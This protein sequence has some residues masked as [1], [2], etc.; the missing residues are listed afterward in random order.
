MKAYDDPKTIL[1]GPVRASYANV[2]KPRKKEG[3]NGQPDRFMFDIT[4]LIPKKAHPHLAA[5]QAEY[6]GIAEAVRQAALHKFGD[7]VK[8]Y[9]NPLKDGDTELR[10]DGTPV[11]PGYWFVAAN[12]GEDY[13]PLVLGPGRERVD[14]SSGYQSGDW[15]KAKIN[16]SAF[17]V[18]NTKG[19]KFYLSAV[20]WLHKDVPFGG[21]G[22]SANDFD[23]E[24]EAVG[25]STYDPFADE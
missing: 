1:I 13:P 14:A 8:V 3:K 6:D 11:A 25:S 4:L 20:Q 24:S 7:K 19:V 5:P 23:D 16:A 18:D 15:V 12:T 2:F 9:K 17:D 21:A 22:A 10:S